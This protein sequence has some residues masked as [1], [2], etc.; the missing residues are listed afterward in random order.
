MTKQSQRSSSTVKSHRSSGFTLIEAVVATAVFAFVISSSLGVYLSTIQLDRKSRAGRAV[1]QNARFIMEYLAKEV[2]N[3]TINYA[4]YPGGLVDTTCFSGLG[5]CSDLYLENQANIVEHIFLS[6]TNLVLNKN[7]SNTNLNSSAVL[8][9]NARF[10]IQPRGDPYT[11]AKT[12]NEQ[13]RVTIVIEL[14]SNYGTSG[15][16][17]MNLQDSFATRNYAPRQ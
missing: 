6:G 12:F 8:V 2:R 5:P 9:T 3:G 15:T 10:A 1:S 4:S 13:P 11:T 17:T 7:G 16:I 14:K